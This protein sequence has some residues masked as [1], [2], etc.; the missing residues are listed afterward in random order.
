MNHNEW[1]PFFSVKQTG[2]TGLSG[3]LLP[4]LSGSRFRVQGSKVITD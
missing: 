4:K 3:S 2:F 1:I